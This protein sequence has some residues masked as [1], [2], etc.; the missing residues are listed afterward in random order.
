MFERMKEYFRLGRVF[1]A[2]ILSLV[3]MLSY[4]LCSKIYHAPIDLKILVGLFFAGLCAHVWG[5][6]HNDR[7]DINIDKKAAYCAHKP[8]VS[9]SISVD[10]ARKVEL[11][12]LAIFIVL[13]I[14]LSPKISTAVYLF[15]AVYLAY[16]YNRYN[17]YSLFIDIV[18]PLNACFVV[19]IGMSIVV[20]LD[21]I[22]LLSAIVMGLNSVY[23]NIIEADLKDIEGD[24]VNVPKSL[25]VRFENGVAVN[26]RKFRIVNECIKLCMFLLIVFILFLENAS[27]TPKMLA[28][29]FFGINFVVRHYMFSNLSSNREKM[30]PTIAIQ[31]LTAILMISTV[32]MVVHPLLPF[33]I[34][35]FVAVWLSLWNRLLWGT[36]LR[37]QV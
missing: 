26:T 21:L 25:G 36:F 12:A 30:K 8:L 5:S 14:G 24:T 7:L 18:G 3:F 22:L 4:A 17:K 27:L 20:D 37:P 19:L 34:V 16:L 13:I 33:A 31:E 10:N 9:G 32:Y 15:G 6:I 11:I 29:A 2:E 28:L 1:N 35:I 23:L